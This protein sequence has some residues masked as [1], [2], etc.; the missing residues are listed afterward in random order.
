MNRN[1]LK[2]LMIST[3]LLTMVFLSASG[4]SE[5][6]KGC[7]CSYT[8]P[9]VCGVDTASQPF[10]GEADIVWDTLLTDSCILG[11]K[12]GLLESLCD[13]PLGDCGLTCG[14]GVPCLSCYEGSN[15]EI[16]KQ[17]ACPNT[18]DCSNM[19]GGCIDG[20]PC[21][22]SNDWIGGGAECYGNWDN[23]QKACIQCSSSKTQAKVYGHSGGGLNCCGDEDPS[24]CLATGNNL[25]ELA[26]GA[27]PV[28]DEH[29]PISCTMECSEGNARRNDCCNAN[30]GFY[31]GVCMSSCG[32]AAACNLKNPGDSCGSGMVCDDS[33][34]CI[35]LTS[36]TTSTSSTTTTTISSGCASCSIYVGTAKACD[37]DTM[38][39][40]SCGGCCGG[41]DLWNCMNS[42]AIYPGDHWALLWSWR[43]RDD[44]AGCYHSYFYFWR[45]N[46]DTD[47]WILE[48]NW[49]RGGYCDCDMMYEWGGRTAPA[50]GH[51]VYRVIGVATTYPQNTPS[52][53][54]ENCHDA[55]CIHNKDPAATYTIRDSNTLTVLTPPCYYFDETSCVADDN[56]MWCDDCGGID[57]VYSPSD[58]CVEKTS[59][60]SYTVCSAS[61]GGKMCSRCNGT[62]LNAWNV[63]RC[64]PLLTDCGY[65]CVQG[66]CR[67]TCD[68]NADCPV[69]YVCNSTCG[70]SFNPCDYTTQSD[71]T[72]NGCKWCPGCGGTGNLYI[73]SDRCI[74][75]TSTCLYDMCSAS[76]GGKLCTRCNNTMINTWGADTC[77]ASSTSCG[78]HCTQGQC[79]A[80]CD[81]N[82]DCS[83]GWACIG[84][85]CTDVE[86]VVPGDCPQYNCSTVTC[87]ATYNCVYT[88]RTCRDNCTAPGYICDGVNRDC[89]DADSSHTACSCYG[90][91][92]GCIWDPQTYNCCGDDGAADNWCTTGT[93]SDP[94]NS[95]VGGVF[96]DS[97]CIDGVSNCDEITYDITSGNCVNEIDCGFGGDGCNPGGVQSVCGP[98]CEGCNCINVQLSSSYISTKTMVWNTISMEFSNSDLSQGKPVE[99]YIEDESF[100]NL[101]NGFCHPSSNC[102]PW[103]FSFL[104]GTGEYP[105]VQSVN[106][107]IPAGATNMPGLASFKFAAPGPTPIDL[108]RI[109]IGIRN[110]GQT[111]DCV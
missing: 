51:Y 64:V 6:C 52:T 109:K 40:S 108:Y 99:V 8:S 9:G 87:N 42:P 66:Q 30:C 69:G 16:C 24:S 34:N 53:S 46:T 59:G 94:G 72:N 45:H 48:G 67:A 5:K 81:D 2:L 97:H 14:Y 95:C 62:L 77:V 36:S 33:C 60:C 98:C 32:A 19:P 90:S 50:P 23:S 26:C 104:N 25:C 29:G 35:P 111:G 91:L 73:P 57:N 70:C 103:S 43:A 17:N 78:Y 89:V 93:A 38:S 63:N 56:C 86:C 44:S 13:K 10:Y 18:N 7:F 75:Q 107:F 85:Q 1:G 55:T 58:P 106:I 47:E 71:C 21:M 49:G 41:T 102:E 31:D 79:G 76:C 27:S 3:V 101:K 22:V 84:C 20:R 61:C 92:Y 54:F 83:P 105:G 100:Q 4:Y 82:S 37:D 28:C 39:E 68:D 110:R 65:H 11:S 88:P 74:P 96:F 12:G 15:N 80:A